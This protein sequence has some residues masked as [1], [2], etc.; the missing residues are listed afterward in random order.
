MAKVKPFKLDGVWLFSD[1]TEILDQIRAEK[2]TRYRETSNNLHALLSLGSGN[3]ET[4]ET[5]ERARIKLSWD[6]VEDTDLKAQINALSL[7]L[8]LAFDDSGS[9]CDDIECSCDNI[10]AITINTKLLN[11]S[12]LILN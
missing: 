10:V 11:K 4:I 12:E 6:A 3:R 5:V 2:D 7:K 8:G 9:T 1:G